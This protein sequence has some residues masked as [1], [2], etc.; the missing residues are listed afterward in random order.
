MPW[1]CLPFKKA[2]IQANNNK[3]YVNIYYL[4][5]SVI[6]T[7]IKALSVLE[8]QKEENSIPNRG[9]GEVSIA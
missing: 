1:A 6:N 2:T 8:L 9:L 7:K 5:Q 4:G 3:T